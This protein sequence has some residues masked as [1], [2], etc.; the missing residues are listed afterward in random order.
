LEASFCSRNV[1]GVYWAGTFIVLGYSRLSGANT[2]PQN[3]SPLES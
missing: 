2:V 3:I 1:R